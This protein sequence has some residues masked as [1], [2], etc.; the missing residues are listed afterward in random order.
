MVSRTG[1]GRLHLG[2][3]STRTIRAKRLM[4]VSLAAQFDLAPLDRVGP[5]AAAEAL[6]LA[7]DSNVHCD[8]MAVETTPR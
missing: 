4:P 6:P 5:G 1:M 8:C 2:H 3:V 7:R